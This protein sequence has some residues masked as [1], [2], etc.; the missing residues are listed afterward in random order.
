VLQIKAF[1]FAEP[2]LCQVKAEERTGLPIII[3]PQSYTGTLA[4][5]RGS[6]KRSVDLH[7]F[8]TRNITSR[9]ALAVGLLYSAALQRLSMM[10][11]YSN[12][13]PL[14]ALVP[15]PP[16]TF[17]LADLKT[18][19]NYI[20]TGEERVGR[21]LLVSLWSNG[22]SY[23]YQIQ[24]SRFYSDFLRSL[25]LRRGPLSLVSTTQELLE[26]KSSCP[27]LETKITGIG[28]R[29]AD[30]MALSTRKSWH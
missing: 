21:L 16:A 9:L 25:G 12:R 8:L 23:W 22:Q 26:S 3:T 17:S 2:I 6:S 29:H 1:E 28:I 20:S 24:R 15:Q 7:G 5:W 13:A 19:S 30:H 18:V 14:Q 11:Y 10:I 4:L 27:G